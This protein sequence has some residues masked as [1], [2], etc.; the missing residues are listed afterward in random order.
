MFGCTVLRK[1]ILN[2]SEGM[3][4]YIIKAEMRGSGPNH[5]NGLFAPRIQLVFLSLSCRSYFRN[6]F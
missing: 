6:V 1:E 2:T 5:L 3:I 4:G